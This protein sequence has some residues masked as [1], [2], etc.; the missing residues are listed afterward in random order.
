MEGPFWSNGERL[1][2][3]APADGSAAAGPN[4]NPAAQNVF[5]ARS[6]AADITRHQPRQLTADIFGGQL[7]LEGE[8]S[9]LDNGKFQ[10]SATLEDADLPEV[11]RQLA[12]QQ[13]GLSGKIFAV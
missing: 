12:P 2:F 7:T 10:V 6:Q 11:A 1:V 13:R 5:V 3:G 8:T 9:L 4:N